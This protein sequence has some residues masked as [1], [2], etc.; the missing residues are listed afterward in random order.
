MHFYLSQSLGQLSNNEVLRLQKSLKVILRHENKPDRL[1]GTL[2]SL[3]NNLQNAPGLSQGSFQKLLIAGGLLCTEEMSE[4]EKSELASNPFT[5]WPNSHCCSIAGEALEALKRDDR[6]LKDGYLFAFISR[7]TSREIKAWSTWLSRVH[8]LPRKPSN[9]QELYRYL[10]LVR[11]SRSEAG[12]ETAR[13]LSGKDLKAVLRDE[14]DS[15]MHWFYRDI[16]PFYRSL[17]DLDAR[18]D[19]EGQS[20]VKPVLQAFLYGDVIS[21]GEITGFGEPLKYTIVKTREK[22]PSLA[23]LKAVGERDSIENRTGESSPSLF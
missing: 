22:G 1:K 12:S 2:L 21:Y 16:L 7:L 3:Y 6:F 15:P 20:S 10:L 18:M 11:A 13:E 9:A 23:A 5:V 17:D 14:S 4:T 8:D 19:K